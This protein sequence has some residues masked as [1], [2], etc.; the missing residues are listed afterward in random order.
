[1]RRLIDFHT[2]STASDG[3]CSPAEVVMLAG[4]ARLVAVALTDHDTVSGLAAAQ[5]AESGSVRFIGGVELSAMFIGGTMHLLGLGLDATS[6]RLK[7]LLA[8]QQAARAQRDP[9][10]LAKLRA[11]GVDITMDDVL[12][13]AGEQRDAGVNR[14][15]GILPV[16][17]MGVS[18]M[19]TLSGE[20]TSPSQSHADEI[21]TSCAGHGRDARAT[22]REGE[23]PSSRRTIG[24]M[25][26]AQ[27]LLR[28]GYVQ[29][30]SEA[31]ARYLGNDAPAYVDKERLAPAQVIDTI[32]AAG[33]LAVLAHPV[34]LR[35]ENRLQIERVVRDLTDHGLDGVEAYHSDHDAVYTRMVLD[36]A[37]RLGLGATGGSDFHG[38]AKP[39]VQLG[40]PP[41]P[42]AALNEKFRRHLG[43]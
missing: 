12:R 17:R 24:R 7:A 27:A 23:T 5:A 30:V 34:S 18:P 41:T 31:F 19:Q 26:F 36:L 10:M 11:L 37:R 13:G 3:M 40:L 33:G 15:T 25:H 20:Q 1:M 28:K 9:Q 42:L 32:H 43:L 35:L 4:R 38:T 29:T 2:H 14:S 21:A 22:G 16:S 39:H 6:P 8:D